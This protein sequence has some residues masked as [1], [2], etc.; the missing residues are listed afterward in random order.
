MGT[1]GRLEGKIAIVTGGLGGIGSAI[2]R[3]FTAEGAAVVIAD[4]RDREGSEL[5]E[6]L[7]PGAFYARLDVTQP[8]AWQQVVAECRDRFG[9]PNVLIANAGINCPR[10]IADLTREDF[11][12]VYDVNV[13]GSFLG[14]QALAPVMIEAGGGSIVVMSSAASGTGL[15]AHAVYGTSKAANASLAR[16]AAVE[17]AHTGIRV[18]SIHPGGIDTDMSRSP[19]FEG[20]DKEAWYRG[21]PIPRI[22][23]ADEVA[24]AAL[25]LASDASS[26]MTGSQIVVDGGQLAG[27]VGVL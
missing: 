21:L 23:R 22:G 20:I 16:N 27:P 9:L 4:V 6:E 19:E 2:C 11:L 17:Y 8:N 26:Y 1:T 7:A 25:F 15:A 10:S 12:R 13:V 14:I 18:N 24:Q 5:A 3:L